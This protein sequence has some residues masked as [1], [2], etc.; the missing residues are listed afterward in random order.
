MKLGKLP[1]RKD[2]RTL[3][4]GAYRT[5][6]LTAPNQAHWG[7]RAKPYGM[8]GNDDY[9]DCA[10]AAQ[11]HV[12]QM[13]AIDSGSSTYTPTEQQTLDAYSAIT[14][15]SPTNPNSDRGTVLLDALNYWKGTGFPG[16]PHPISAFMQVSPQS[17]DEV[18][19]SVAYYGHLYIGLQLPLSA[20]DQ[21]GTCW[22]VGT[23]SSAQAGSWGGHCV[24]I[25]GYTASHLWCITWGD[26]QEMDWDFFNTYCDEAYVCLS[27]D[28]MKSTDRSPSGLAWGTLMTDLANL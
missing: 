19:E 25:S 24:P 1:A 16:A 10:E 6:S 23:G 9:G 14:G 4:Y 12:E 7:R 2:P 5:A 20:Q 27:Q 8:L 21:V 11:G 17:G 15:F 28:W 22:T 3:R 13:W 18:R 26:I